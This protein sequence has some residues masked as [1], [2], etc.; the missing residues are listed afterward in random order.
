MACVI[1]GTIRINS[2][3]GGVVNFG[4]AL[5][6]SSETIEFGQTGNNTSPFTPTGVNDGGSEAGTDPNIT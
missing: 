5:Y 1:I 6:I 3:S 2:I 4:D